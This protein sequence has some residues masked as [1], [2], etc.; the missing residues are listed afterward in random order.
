MNGG[1]FLADRG[2]S[3]APNTR[4]P[5]RPHSHP[6]DLDQYGKELDKEAYE[7]KGVVSNKESK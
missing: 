7:D 4:N 2:T 6:S 3:N 1:V 5:E